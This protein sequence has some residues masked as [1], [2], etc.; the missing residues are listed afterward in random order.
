MGAHTCLFV[1]VMF[2]VANRSE[3]HELDGNSIVFMWL[4]R[5][6][7]ALHPVAVIVG[8]E[9]APPLMEEPEEPRKSI[10]AR[11]R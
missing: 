5:R 3:D 10:G 8:F 11:H 4:G 9:Y 7:R 2:G 1:C 6:E